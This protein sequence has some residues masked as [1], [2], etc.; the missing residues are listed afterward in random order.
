MPV[1]QLEHFT[2]RCSDL[3]MTRDFYRDILGLEVGPRPPLPF[4]GYWLYVGGVPTVHLVDAS[5]A[6][7]MGGDRDTYEHTGSIDHVAFLGDDFESFKSLLQQKDLNF[8]TM[9]FPGFMDQVF[10]SDP[11]NVLVEITFR[12]GNR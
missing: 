8:E 6:A 10:I 11:D 4:K 9:S 3:D 5:E 12:H 7:T 2:I 1:S